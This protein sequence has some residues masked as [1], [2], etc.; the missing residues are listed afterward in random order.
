MQLL[1]AG[2]SIR[3]TWPSPRPTQYVRESSRLQ[4][5]CAQ[6]SQVSGRVNLSRCIKQ[7][8][9]LLPTGRRCSQA[10]LRYAL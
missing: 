3:N 6:V 8:A 9:G 1:Q 10:G 5:I 2:P 4:H 7:K